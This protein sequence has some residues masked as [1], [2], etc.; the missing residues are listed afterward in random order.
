MPAGAVPFGSIE[1]LHAFLHHVS[2]PVLSIE[3]RR[4]IW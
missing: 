3:H 4:L 1:S 2:L